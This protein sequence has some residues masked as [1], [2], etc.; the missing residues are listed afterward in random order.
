MIQPPPLPLLG[1]ANVLSFTGGFVDVVGFA[2]LFGLFANHMTGNIVMIGISLS[3]S[4]PGML[5]KLLAIPVFIGSVALTRLMILRLAASGY[6]STRILY[7]AQ[8]LLLILF[9][10]TALASLPHDDPNDPWLV[11]AGLFAVA[12][13]SVQNTQGKLLDPQC[14]P[15]TVM[16]GNLVQAVIDFVDLYLAKRSAEPGASQRLKQATAAI[17]SFIAGAVLGA[18]M[19]KNLSFACLGMPVLLLLLLSFMPGGAYIG[20]KEMKLEMK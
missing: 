13:M 15:T 9:M 19:L 8:A 18:F 6:P 7:M 5:L 16:T 17:V 3:Y 10:V 12:A 1:R 4:S 11:C 2:A 14:V 20:N